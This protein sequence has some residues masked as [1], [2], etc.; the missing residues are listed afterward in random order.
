MWSR[1]SVALLAFLPG[2]AWC[3]PFTPQNP[4]EG[5]SASYHA[6]RSLATP[7]DQVQVTLEISNHTSGTIEALDPRDYGWSHRELEENRRSTCPGPFHIY[8]GEDHFIV[9][10]PG[11]TFTVTT[12]Y[13]IPSCES[14]STGVRIFHTPYE[15]DAC[16][17]YYDEKRT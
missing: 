1:I 16:V 3:Q 17:I 7:G 12:V 2:A 5:V 8:D 10:A 11:E 4:I 14:R 15:A 13:T 9:L 6:D